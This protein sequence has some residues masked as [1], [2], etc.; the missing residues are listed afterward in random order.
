MVRG[1]ILSAGC[2]WGALSFVIHSLGSH[3]AGNRWM[4][5]VLRLVLAAATMKQ[6]GT[7][8]G[9]VLGLFIIG[10]SLMLLP[11]TVIFCLMETLKAWLCLCSS[12]SGG[13]GRAKPAFICAP[14][15]SP[16]P[17]SSQGG[18]GCDGSPV[19]DTCPL[20]RGL[21]PSAVAHMQTSV[22]RVGT[23]S[24]P[25]CQSRVWGAVPNQCHH[26]TGTIWRFSWLA[27]TSAEPHQLEGCVLEQTRLSSAFP[28]R[29]LIYLRDC[30]P[31]TS[32]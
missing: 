8:L 20:G 19:G 30:A 15:L 11:G 24:T 7:H 28:N 10:T 6:V 23:A 21:K 2:P 17:P 29:V 16:N 14:R 22:C 4:W 3:G 27:L 32:L 31:S 9:C 1:L 13:E 25:Q 26:V 18:P 5:V 12:S